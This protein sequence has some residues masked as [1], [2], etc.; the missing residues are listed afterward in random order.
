MVVA[1]RP[2]VFLQ[3]GTGFEIVQTNHSAIVETYAIFCNNSFQI[4]RNISSLI[5]SG[6]TDA[7]SK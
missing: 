4:A 6:N 3:E 7:F 2:F 5:I 1:M